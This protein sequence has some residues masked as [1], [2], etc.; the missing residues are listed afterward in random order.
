MT[1]NRHRAPHIFTRLE[2]DETIEETMLVAN[3]MAEG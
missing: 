1:T 2:E 3:R